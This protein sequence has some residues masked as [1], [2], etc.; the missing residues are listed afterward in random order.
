[1]VGETIGNFRIV[2]KLGEGGVGSVYRAID[3]MVE[4]EVAIKVLKP[5]GGSELGTYER[6]RTEAV[7]LAKLNH[8]CIATLYSFFREGDEYFMVMEYVRGQ[9]LEQVLRANGRMDWRRSIEIMLPV[10]DGV[11][12]AHANGI[13][14]RDLKPANIMLP[15]EGGVKITDF[16]IARAFRGKRL[17]LENRIVGTVEYMA[18]ERASGAEVDARS[19]LFSLGVVF[20]QMLTGQ[21]PFKGSNDYELLNA[22][23]RLAPRPLQEYGV[24]VPAAVE[25][26]LLTAMAKDPAQR[27]QSAAEFAGQ[28]RACLSVPDAP[29]DLDKAT[30]Y[31]PIAQEPTAPPVKNLNAPLSAAKPSAPVPPLSSGLAQNAPAKA[32]FQLPPQTIKLAAVAGGAV[33]TLAVLS[34]ITLHFLNRPAV[35]VAE[36][37]SASISVAPAAAP[38]APTV[39][40]PEPAAPSPASDAGGSTP[41][42]PPPPDAKPAPGSGTTPNTAPGPAPKPK[43]KSEPPPAEPSPEPAPADTV[44]PPPEPRPNET[45]PEP[46]PAAPSLPSVRNLHDVRKIFLEPMPEHLDEFLSQELVSEFGGRLQV[47]G[48]PN[49]ADAVLAVAI[50]DEHGHRVTGAA[51]RLVGLKG[52]KRAIATLRNSSG[53]QLWTAD[54]NDRHS[55]VTAMRDDMKRL[56]SR[57]AKR[58]RSD[59]K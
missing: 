46:A 15:S 44:A 53:E 52:S 55:L 36:V 49:S 2:E 24:A 4:R 10:L 35:Q 39:A 48:A 31:V 1:M 28:L 43:L 5:D 20:Y 7:A 11:R 33:V 22:V 14:H 38:P 6:F 19:D 58:L 54:V 3:Q 29:S 59:L 12:H 8:P 45:V 37:K 32:G 30:R 56:A 23:M 17:T 16:G 27:Q 47:T 34:L 57:I 40:T 18:P 26:T 50:E 21:L 51:G 25:Q 42:W 13:V 9:N 41:A